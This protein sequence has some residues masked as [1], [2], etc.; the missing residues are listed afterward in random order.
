MGGPIA[1]G[2]RTFVATLATRWSSTMPTDPFTGVGIKGSAHAV[3]HGQATVDDAIAMA[4]RYAE[5]PADHP[6]APLREPNPCC[7]ESRGM[8][9]LDTTDERPPRRRPETA[10]GLAPAGAMRASAAVIGRKV[11]MDGAN[12]GAIEPPPQWR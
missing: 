9:K 6:P 8:P 10:G 5:D 12:V 11:R 2:Q 7:R 4:R 3:R 1:D